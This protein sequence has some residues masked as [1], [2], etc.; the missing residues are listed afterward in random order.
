MILCHFRRF[1]TD[2]TCPT[3]PSPLQLCSESTA[4]NK[5]FCILKKTFLTSKPLHCQVCNRSFKS[6]GGLTKHLTLIHTGFNDYND[7]DSFLTS[8]EYSGP[9]ASCQHPTDSPLQH[10]LQSPPSSAS[11]NMAP[12]V[13]SFANQKNNEE[14]LLIQ[15]LISWGFLNEL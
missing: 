1:L 3:H 8:S 11:S 9:S 6:R 12:P 15:V 13:S 14:A 7:R 4:P 2:L 10:H 5:F